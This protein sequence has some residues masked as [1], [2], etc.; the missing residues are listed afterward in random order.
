MTRV[1]IDTPH[2]PA[3]AELHC[4]EEGRAALLLGH[5]AGGGIAAPDL[6]AAT[7]AA[8]GA[9]VHV[10][11]V[12]QPYRVAGRKAPAPA[13][14][15]DA[16]WLAVAEDLGERWFADLPLLFGGRSSG[17]RV[18]CRTAEA[19]TASAVLC[20]AFPLHPPGKPEKSRL[21]EL[22]AV[23]PPVLVVQGERDAFGRPEPAHRREVVLVA[24]DHSLKADVD[25]VFRGVEEWL[26]RVLRP[27][28]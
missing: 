19:G 13:K 1:Q 15:L 6:V 12:E 2:G 16:A 9:G 5:G 18:A 21:G 4:A 28:D 7:R 24:G 17:A 23:D 14:Q 27:L 20:L 25:A 3:A 26:T 22:D 10:A 8:T 11:L